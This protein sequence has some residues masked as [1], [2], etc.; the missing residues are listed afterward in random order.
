MAVFH[1]AA[2][3]H[4]K[5]RPWL[6]RIEGT[7]ERYVFHRRFLP[8][9]ESRLT[10][11]GRTGDVTWELDELGLYQLGGSKRD[12]AFFV[13]IEEDGLLTRCKIRKA[14]ALDLAR[15]LDTGAAFEDAWSDVAALR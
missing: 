8:G 14:V 7:H 15:R 11:L 9:D 10:R 12:D 2:C 6:A 4:G 5:H 13:L 1:L 3:A